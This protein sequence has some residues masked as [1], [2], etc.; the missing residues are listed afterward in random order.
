MIDPEDRVRQHIKSIQIALD[1]ESV[2][3]AYNTVWGYL[4]AL[5]D[6]DLI[7]DDQ[8]KKLDKE[9]S[10]AKKARMAILSKKK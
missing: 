7:S 5:N 4:L 1:I 10:N 6:F 2:E 8:I 9:A 3:G